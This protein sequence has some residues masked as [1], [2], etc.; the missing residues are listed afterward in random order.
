MESLHTAHRTVKTFSD[1]SNR[2]KKRIF[3]CVCLAIWVNE[4]DVSLTHIMTKARDQIVNCSSS[5][6]YLFVEFFLYLN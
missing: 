3:H 2:Q 5:F 1:F 6:S 4:I